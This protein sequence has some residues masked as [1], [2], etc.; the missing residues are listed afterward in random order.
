MNT[1]DY[2]NQNKISVQVNGTAKINVVSNLFQGKKIVIAK[3]NTGYVKLLSKDSVKVIMP[4]YYNMD[5]ES[6][7]SDLG[8]GTIDNIIAYNKLDLAL[9]IEIDRLSN[10]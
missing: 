9:Q 4:N 7:I 8:F 6:N 2:I 1:Q 10:L 5:F 3:N